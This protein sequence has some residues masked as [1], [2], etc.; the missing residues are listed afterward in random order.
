M[1]YS[2]A[3]LVQKAKPM[4]PPDIAIPEDIL[5]ELM[6][7][8]PAGY[9]VGFP[10]FDDKLG[11]FRQGEVTLITGRPGSGK[12]TLVNDWIVNLL[13]RYDEFNVFVATLELR[14][15][16]LL[17]W[18]CKSESLDPYKRESYDKLFEIFRRRLMIYSPTNVISVD[19]LLGA[20]EYSARRAGVDFIVI[21]SLMCIN[22]QSRDVDHYES[23]RQLMAQ[24]NRFAAAHSCHIVLIA[25]PRKGQT[26]E[27]RVGMVDIA[28]TADLANLAWNVLGLHRTVDDEGRPTSKTI[29]TILKN[30]ELGTQGAIRLEH[31]SFRQGFQEI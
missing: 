12:S 15:K 2:F 7:K 16:T 25:H 22:L 10:R 3:E 24:L 30:R 14:R 13:K 11:G 17:R 9:R 6:R 8:E 31:S 20:M 19:E 23:Q 1:K 29:L 28:G 27:S 4:S 5:D 26:D 18:F 21:D